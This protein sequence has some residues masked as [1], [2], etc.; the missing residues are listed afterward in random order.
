MAPALH[1]ASA[2]HHE[3]LVGV[4]HVGQAVRDEHHRAPGLPRQRSDDVHDDVFAFHV[5]V[6][7]GLVKEVG[8]SVMEQG[9]GHCQT[10]PLPA[11]EIGRPLGKHCVQAGLP[12]Q[13]PRQAHALKSVPESGVIGA[14]GGHEEVLAHR[15][16]EEVALV[17]HVG[18]MR[19]KV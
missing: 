10:L 16:L 8:R 12:A 1:H 9:A 3:H 19:Q 18:D 14:R 7:R 15:A 2:V 13:E 5:H 11:G 4:H 6:G 17:P